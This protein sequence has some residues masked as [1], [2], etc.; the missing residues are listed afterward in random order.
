[1]ASI[2]LVPLQKLLNSMERTRPAFRD[3][4]YEYPMRLA[5]VGTPAP[6]TSW[7]A[8]RQSGRYMHDR[9][10]AARSAMGQCVRDKLAGLA[11]NQCNEMR[12]LSRDACQWHSMDRFIA[13]SSLRSEA[14]PRLQKLV[15]GAVAF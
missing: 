10:G 7:R 8:E 9:C 11:R 1:M 3:V 6:G 4:N 13:R 15:R 2:D 14:G 12:C 5:E